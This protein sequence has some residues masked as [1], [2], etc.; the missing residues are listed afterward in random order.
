MAK[1]YLE[2]LTKCYHGEKIRLIWD[3]ASSHLSEDVVDHAVDL[4]ITCGWVD[5]DSTSL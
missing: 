3:S 5:F 1:R 4:G 2:W